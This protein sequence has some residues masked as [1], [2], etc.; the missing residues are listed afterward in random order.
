MERDSH[1]GNLCVKFTVNH[2]SKLSPEQIEKL[3]EI[4]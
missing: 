4:L 3:K 2:P 1:K